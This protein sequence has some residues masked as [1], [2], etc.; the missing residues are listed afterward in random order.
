MCHRFLKPLSTVKR[1]RDFIITDE[2]FLKRFIATE[3][4]A[5]AVGGQIGLFAVDKLNEQ[6]ISVIENMYV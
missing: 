1:R 3:R 2:Y 4:D 6:I 5:L